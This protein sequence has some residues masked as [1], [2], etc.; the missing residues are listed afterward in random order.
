MSIESFGFRSHWALVFLAYGKGGV[1]LVK[2]S[3]NCYANTKDKKKLTLST[4][5]VEPPL[6]MIRFAKL[7]AE[8]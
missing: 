5:F 1:S 2:P 6:A 7:N 4:I 8:L 3:D